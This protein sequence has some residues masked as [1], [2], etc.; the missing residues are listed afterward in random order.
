[1]TEGGFADPDA[2]GMALAAAIR[3]L[4]HRGPD[5]EST[6]SDSH[7]GLACARLAVI[8]RSENGNQPFCDSTGTAWLVCNGEIYNHEDLRSELTGLG[9]RFRSNT[10]VEVIVHGY[11]QWGIDVF[12]R[13][14][15]MFA[16]ALWDSASRTLILA[17]DPVGEK[18]LYYALS[19]KALAF[20]SEIKAILPMGVVPRSPD[21]TAIHHY[22]T[23]QYVPAPWTAFAGINS[24]PP[25][26]SLTVGPDGTSKLTTFFEMP[27]RLGPPGSDLG[28]E[29]LAT[30]ETAVQ[31]QLRA[32]VALGAFLSGGVDS[33]AVVALM[34]RNSTAPIKT[35]AAGFAQDGH[36]ERAY[37]R[38]VAERYQTDHH[39]YLLSPDMP[40]LM[41]QL[42]W[43]YG[44]PFA[45]SSAVP[46]FCLS[47][48]AREHV[49]VV[50]TGDGGDELFFGYDRYGAFGKSRVVDSLPL[51]ARSLAG[52]VAERMPPGLDRSRFMR[53]LRRMLARLDSRNSRRYAP[54]MA[55]FS[56]S[57]KALG[58]GSALTDQL[59][60]SSLDL[61]Q[62]YFNA[63]PDMVS[64]AAWTD[65][66]TY[67][68][69]DILMK[70][71]VASMAHGLE[72]RSPL[73]DHD[74]VQWA[75]KLSATQ[76]MPGGELK[77]LLKSALSGVLPGQVLEREKMGFRAPLK[78]WM[79]GSLREMTYD[80]L[81]SKAFRERELFRPDYV[82]RLLS[83]HHAGIMD[84]HPRL[85]ALLFLELWFEMW[86]DSDHLPEAPRES[87]LASDK[88][89]YGQA[90]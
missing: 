83:E 62:D 27:R 86:I 47:K 82:T 63:Y 22:L 41:G 8:D 51:L 60:D 20:A 89:E 23:L 44:Q 81:G 45:D 58:Y 21:L 7:A 12:S 2:Q 33:S 79:G 11:R 87:G 37:A 69:N 59:E 4:H 78:H 10:D 66:N 30:L 13:L 65:L 61:W 55:F 31:R 46:T 39:E 48:L 15:G 16:V 72:V 88:T 74:V 71:D 36:D 18:P 28:V 29:I 32:D 25:G 40:D 34:A 54:M 56:D 3:L 26:H 75:R 5:Q 67:L 52:C 73:L 64:G 1:L 90:S 17:R 14:A 24:I 43:H 38:L 84:H 57:D 42:V 50:L 68:P 76:L 9:H 19:G 6:W 80:V 53:V 70:L 85:W 77:G 35:F 49:T